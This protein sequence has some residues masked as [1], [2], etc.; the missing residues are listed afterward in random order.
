MDKAD[1][2]EYFCEVTSVSLSESDS[3]EDPANAHAEDELAALVVPVIKEMEVEELKMGSVFEDKKSIC[4]AVL[5]AASNI[6]R[7]VY[8]KKQAAKIIL[9][10]CKG[11]GCLFRARFSLKQQHWQ[12]IVFNEEH[13]CIPASMVALKSE[14][15]QPAI[16][17][18][19]L[20]DPS[21]TSPPLHAYVE[22]S[23]NV[24]VK[25]HMVNLVNR[26]GW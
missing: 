16:E 23:V 9:Y 21:M 5:S 6:G 20:M 24:K 25:R 13:T 2:V 18:A 26:K 22:S 19:L 4:F 7:R 8:I 11:E 3:D 17:R 1:Y 12:M 14:V 10:L 15:I